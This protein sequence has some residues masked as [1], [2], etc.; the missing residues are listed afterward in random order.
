MWCSRCWK[1]FTIRRRY[2]QHIASFLELMKV[3]YTGCNPRGLVLARG[4][5]LSK[6]LAHHRRIAV[7][8]FAVF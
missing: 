3:P 7:P 8:A 6:M 4:R 2:D 1:N 5:D